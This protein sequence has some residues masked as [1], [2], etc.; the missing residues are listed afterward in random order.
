M[1]E[2]PKLRMIYSTRKS[3]SCQGVLRGKCR[4]SVMSAAGL[5]SHGGAIIRLEYGL[6]PLLAFDPNGPQDDRRCYH[7]AVWLIWE[8]AVATKPS[9]AL[10]GTWLIVRLSACA[11]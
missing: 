2:S 10:I 11:Q 4:E 6:V 8:R 9:S 3:V 7:T 1:M 5:G